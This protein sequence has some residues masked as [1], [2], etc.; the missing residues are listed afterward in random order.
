MIVDLT[1]CRLAVVG[2][3]KREREIAR[4]GAT[5]GARVSAFGFPW[6]EA[7]IPGVERAA[8]AAGALD[9]AGIA[10]F[11]LPGLK[12]GCLYAPAAVEPIRPD[13]LLLGRMAKPA[14][15]LLGHADQ[16]LREA[17]GSLG[18]AL[19]EYENDYAGRRLRAPAVVEGA[20]AALI[21]NTEF[22]LDGARIAV[23]GQGVIGSLL[24]RRLAALGARVVA[25]ARNAEQR[26]QAAAD[27]LEA[28][29][30]EELAREA[31]SLDVLVSTASARVVDRA[32]LA[33]LAPG[34]LVVDIASP[35]GSVDLEAATALGLKAVW[36]RGL[37]AR[38]PI[39]VGRAQW[40]VIAGILARVPR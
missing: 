15:V 14:H 13:A 2:G 25:V 33:S 5:S 12:D 9:G 24:A 6:P 20:L 26:N 27:G 7:G 22:A 34:T 31:R 40:E 29:S 1:G 17:A 18:I 39:T 23:L 32:L 3:D 37:G 16:A 30:F 21:Q 8:G 10:L 35:P 36:A 4:L 38:A 11:P 19:H 28:A